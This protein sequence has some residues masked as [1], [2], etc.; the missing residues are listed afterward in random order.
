MKI[1][2]TKKALISYMRQKCEEATRKVAR[3]IEVGINN[4]RMHENLRGQASAWWDAAMLIADWDEVAEDKTRTTT[5]RRKK[6]TR[7]L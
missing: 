3:Q 6:T 4:P 2:M 1:T 5:D 7:R